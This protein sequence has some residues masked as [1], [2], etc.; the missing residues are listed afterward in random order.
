MSRELCWSHLSGV[1]RCGGGRGRCWKAELQ[2]EGRSSRRQWGPVCRG[3]AS[4]RE[5]AGGGR[6]GAAGL[7]LLAPSDLPS[8][9]TPGLGTLGRVSAVGLQEAKQ[10]PWPPPRRLTAAGLAALAVGEASSPQWAPGARLGPGLAGEAPWSAVR[11]GSGSRPAGLREGG[12]ETCELE[13]LFCLWK[14][15]LIMKAICVHSP[16]YFA[17]CPIRFGGFYFCFFLS[18]N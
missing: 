8:S 10:Q 16:S 2:R 3:Q 13:T 9:L 15:F 6:R 7:R 5:E 1:Q 17:D 12:V 18:D 14:C 11:V 4:F